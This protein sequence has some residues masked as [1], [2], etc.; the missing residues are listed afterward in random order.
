MATRC[1]PRLWKRHASGNTRKGSRLYEWALIPIVHEAALDKGECY[2][3][4]LLVRRGLNDHS[5]RSYYVVYDPTGANSLEAA[6]RVAGVRWSM[7]RE[8]EAAR[9]EC[10]L[11]R[12][13]VRKWDSWY[14][15]ITLSLLAHAFRM[16]MVSAAIPDDRAAQRLVS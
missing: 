16:A 5:D 1:D 4:S 7:E 10:G 2:E 11:D 13:E 8:L 9:K 6:I 12:Y 3:H 14:R 15:H